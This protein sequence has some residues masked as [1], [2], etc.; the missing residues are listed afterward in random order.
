MTPASHGRRRAALVATSAWLLLL[1]AS[2]SAHPPTASFDYAPE[3]PEPGELVEFR[4]TSV[5]APEHTE[6]MVLDWD[7]DA[8]GQ[9]DDASGATA[10]RA[11][12]AGDHVV[13]LRARYLSAAGSHEDV[14]ERTVTVGDAAAASAARG[15]ARAVR[16]ARAGRQPG[17][18]GG[19]RQG[20]HEDGRVPGLRRTVRARAEAAH[21]RRLALA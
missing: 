16:D 11:Y 15:D 18:G 10:R 19:V 4:S 14:A 1:A 8:D 13:R 5:P 6:P 9:F 12:A 20:L 2:A 21:D 3:Q 17:A 7:L